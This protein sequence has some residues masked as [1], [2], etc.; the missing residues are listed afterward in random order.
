[1]RIAVI[2]AGGVGGYFGA[3]LAAAGDDVTFVARGRHLAAIEAN[4]LTV[5]S[6]LGDLRVPPTAVVPDIGDVKDADVVLVAVKLW[7]TEEVARRLRPLAEAGAAVVSFQNGVQKD[8]VLRAHVPAAAVMGGVSY[9]SAWIEEPGVVVH[10]GPL[11]KLVFGGYGPGPGA[12][13]A[14]EL[15]DRCLAAG[16]EAAVSTDIERVI[17]EKFV[18]LVG[19]SA[20]TSAVRQPI[21][22]VRGTPGSRALLADV[23]REAAAVGRARGVALDPGLA[24]ERL[25]FCDTLPAGMTSSMHNDLVRGNRLEVPWLSGAVAALGRELGV[26]TP[27]NSA[28]ADILAPYVLG[29]PQEPAG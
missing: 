17:W 16:I 6:R 8:D 19:L 29:A 9:I 27:R 7:D 3:R 20:T 25:A 21:G 2:G 24:E 18:F 28:V 5:R 4:G 26:P 1:M 22:V 10:N 23:M 11:Q 13:R 15:L 14:A 12:D